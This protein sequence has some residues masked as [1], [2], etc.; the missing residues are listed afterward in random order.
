MNRTF[1]AIIKLIVTLIQITIVL[2][3]VGIG[4][5]YY[6][7]F[8]NYSIQKQKKSLLMILIFITIVIIFSLYSDN[9]LV[10]FSI[11]NTINLIKSNG[12]YFAIG[13]GLLITSLVL[14]QMM[15]RISKSIL[16]KQDASLDKETIYE[17]IPLYM[18]A[19]SVFLLISSGIIALIFKYENIFVGIFILI[20]SEILIGLLGMFFDLL[21]FSESEVEN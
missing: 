15:I 3:L 13:F 18:T 11:K 6:N 14:G 20:L 7:K 10:D 2:L 16:K 9:Y 8:A 1:N 5:N 4:L 21:I 12:K 19:L 17:L